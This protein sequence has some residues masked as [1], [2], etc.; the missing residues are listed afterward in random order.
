MEL[1]LGEA[2]VVADVVHRPARFLVVERLAP[3]LVEAEAHPDRVQAGQHAVEKFALQVVVVVVVGLA[4]PV[5]VVEPQGGPAAL[6]QLRQVRAGRLVHLDVVQVGALLAADFQQ[7]AKSVGGDQAGFGA[8]MLDQRIRR[9]GRAVREDD[10]VAKV[11]ARVD[12]A[13]DDGLDRI[14]RRGNL[15]HL[16][17]ATLVEDQ[18]HVQRLDVTVGRGCQ[19][20]RCSRS[21]HHPSSAARCRMLRTVPQDTAE[22]SLAMMLSASVIIRS[23]TAAA[24]S[25][26]RTSPTPSPAGIAS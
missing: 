19:D 12:D 5:G 26:D 20:C 18:R 8:A 13:R 9:D 11:D 10:D 17:R 21:S 24:G 3:A 14:L 15:P 22:A 16:N 23:I 4:V 1:E 25:M 6:A 2:V 7:V